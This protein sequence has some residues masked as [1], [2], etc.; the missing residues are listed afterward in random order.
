MDMRNY[1]AVL[2]PI[3]FTSLAAGCCGAP[4]QTP[5]ITCIKSATITAEAARQQV[6]LENATND[7]PPGPLYW[8]KKAEDAGNAMAN[9]PRPVCRN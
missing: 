4:A 6:Y 9:D 1:R 5:G 3:I 8:D 7:V 2:V